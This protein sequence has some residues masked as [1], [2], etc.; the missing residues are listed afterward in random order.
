MLMRAMVAVSFVV[1]ATGLAQPA[2]PKKE[3]DKVIII[4]DYKYIEQARFNK[5][6]KEQTPVEV[7]V[8]QTVVWKNLDGDAH[9]ARSDAQGDL[10]K[11]AI[12]NTKAIKSGGESKVISFDEELFKR[13][14]GKP[15]GSIEI[16]YHCQYHAEMKDAVIVLID[17]KNKKQ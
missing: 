14:G 6:E 15:G 16:K 3:A 17:K 4:K 13:A 1:L 9:T 12:F 10:E 7:N 11:G 8:G 2:Q 5:E